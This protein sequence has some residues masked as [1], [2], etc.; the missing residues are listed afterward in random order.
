VFGLTDLKFGVWF[1]KMISLG[2]TPRI[3]N[4]QIRA[5]CGELEETK[6]VTLLHGLWS[7][8]ELCLPKTPSGSSGFLQSSCNACYALYIG[9]IP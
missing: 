7:T 9:K 1:A 6:N 4:I 5:A 3:N 2:R 8:V